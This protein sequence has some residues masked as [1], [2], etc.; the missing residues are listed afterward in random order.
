MLVGT[1]C[2][3]LHCW[4]L[5]KVLKTDASAC[6]VGGGF[7]DGFGW[8][9]TDE[10][11][12]IPQEMIPEMIRWYK[13]GQFPVENL[14]RFYPFEKVNSAMEAMKEH[15]KKEDLEYDQ[16][17]LVEY[18]DSFTGE[19]VKEHKSKPFGEVVGKQSKPVSPS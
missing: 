7:V 12:S 4:E 9:C 8:K 14:M 1:T 13:K 19:P 11:F 16:M 2:T 15:S 17:T 10:G 5:P 6:E 3:Q 18:I